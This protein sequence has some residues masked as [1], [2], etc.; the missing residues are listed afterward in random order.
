MKVGMQNRIIRRFN[1]WEAF[2]R[3]KYYFL[4]PFLFLMA[5]TI[6]IAFSL[7]VYYK[8]SSTI[9][10][11]ESNIPEGIVEDN[12]LGFVDQRLETI[13]QRI[14]SRTRLWNLIEKHKLYQN[15]K[16]KY[17]QE[18]LVNLI[19]ERINIETISSDVFQT[20]SS[21]A[22]RGTIS[23]T[24]SFDDTN[25]HVA[26]N[27]ANRLARLFIQENEANLEK[28]IE[29]TVSFL[30]KEANISRK[31]LLDLENKIADFKGKHMQEM[32]D[33][34]ESNIEKVA[35]IE[36][37]IDTLQTNLQNLLQRKSETVGQLSMTNPYLTVFEASGERMMEPEDQLQAL[38]YEFFKKKASLSPKHPD[39]IRL[40]SEIEELDKI[41]GKEAQY[42]D[43][44]N[45]LV[46]L[47]AKYIEQSRELGKEHPDLISLKDE[48]KI[49]RDELVNLKNQMINEE[50][51]TTKAPNNPAYITLQTSLNTI[52]LDIKATKEK[53]DNLIKRLAGVKRLINNTPKTEKAYIS[54][55]REYEHLKTIHAQLLTRVAEA[56]AAQE[57]E[58]TEKGEKFTIIDEASFP[59]KPVRPDIFVIIILGL[60]ISLSISSGALFISDNSDKSIRTDSELSEAIGFNVLV[61]IPYAKNSYDRV[62]RFLSIIFQFIIV[63]FFVLGAIWTA[64]YYY[65]NY[66]LPRLP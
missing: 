10:V 42:H 17:T 35:E 33:Q 6:A 1:F 59:Q 15:I 29:D 47:E 14:M 38:R 37:E 52:N 16:H 56:K 22:M 12:F 3:K 26:Q 32:P 64:Y 48:I 40:K 23:F 62:K 4:L 24:L 55:T 51:F 11:E 13:A 65:Y 20:F 44:K 61:S 2:M 21:S 46:G 34:L 30:Y 45:H 63:L 36:G 18:E 43:L 31:K 9:L 58:H 5:A 41:V 27:I 8:S 66:A 53:K 19:K 57:V 7:P 54:L 28:K 49:V 50:V 39:L 25:P 60:I